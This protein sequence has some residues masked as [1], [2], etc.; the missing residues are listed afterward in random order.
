MLLHHDGQKTKKAPF[1]QPKYEK[2]LN[3]NVS[4]LFFLSRPVQ[5]PH[6]LPALQV[7]QIFLAQPDIGRR[8]FH[9][10]VIV[11]EFNGTFQCQLSRCR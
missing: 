7:G 1:V 9:Q 5:L 10:F 3:E 8:Q 2:C 6:M 11:D 4:L